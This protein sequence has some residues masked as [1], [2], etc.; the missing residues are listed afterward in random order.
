MNIPLFFPSKGL[1]LRWHV[2]RNILAERI[3]SPMDICPPPHASQA[4]IPHP[5]DGGLNATRYWIE[6]ADFY[7]LPY[8]TYYDSVP[9]L[10]GVLQRMTEMELWSISKRMKA[11]KALVKADLL[12]KWTKIMRHVA[13]HSGK[14]VSNS[15]RR[16]FE[17]KFIH[18]IPRNNG[19]A[20]AMMGWLNIINIF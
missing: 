8:I 2:E 16:R 18:V 12:R 19:P 6:F 14:K 7:N 10:A 3:F 15:A 17:T 1:L 11:Y 9:Q 5:M 13:T 20:V 4:G